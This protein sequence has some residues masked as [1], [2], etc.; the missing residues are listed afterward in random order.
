MVC[1]ALHE[2][3]K[4]FRGPNPQY[5]QSKLGSGSACGYSNM[6]SWSISHSFLKCFCLKYG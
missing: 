4:A 2:W 6:C 3:Y 5:I 1:M